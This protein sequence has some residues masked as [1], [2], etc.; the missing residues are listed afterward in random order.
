MFEFQQLCNEVEALSPAER[1]ALMTEKAVSV[2][3]ALRKLDLEED[4]VD[5]LVTF[6]LGSVISDGSISEKDYLRLAPS[7]EQAFGDLCDLTGLKQ[8]LKVSRDVV[9]E[10]KDFTAELLGILN[11]ADDQ[12]G[13]DII[14]LCLLVTSVDGKISLKEKKYIKQLCKA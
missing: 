7:L 9:K 12:L 4:P 14:A 6:I 3:D 2:V 11:E 8:T 13:S 5:I 1:A 10:V